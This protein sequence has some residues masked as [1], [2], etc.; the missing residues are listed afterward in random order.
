MSKLSYSSLEIQPYLKSELIY[1]RTKKFLFKLR[2]RMVDVGF[3]FGKKNKCKLCLV[4]NDDQENLL[5]CFKLKTA[6][7]DLLQDLNYCDIFG[8]NIEKQAKMERV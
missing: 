7:P 4:G 3:N 8:D 6:H 2:T 1:N 5:K